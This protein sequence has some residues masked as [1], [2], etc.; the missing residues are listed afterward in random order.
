MIDKITIPKPLKLRDADV[1]SK[2][3]CA[4]AEHMGTDYLV[5]EAIQVA[6][7]RR[8]RSPRLSIL[9]DEHVVVL[10]CVANSTNDQN[11]S[12]LEKNGKIVFD[13]HAGQGISDVAATKRTI[14]VGY[15]DVGVMSDNKISNE[16]LAVFDH[17]GRFLTGYRSSTTERVDVMDCYCIC[18]AGGE[19]IAFHSYPSLQLV[20]WVAMRK[21]HS[22]SEMP[23]IACGSAMIAIH[24]SILYAYSPYRK[25]SSLFRIADDALKLNLDFPSR[26][27]ALRDGR[28]LLLD[29]HSAKILEPDRIA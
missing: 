13:F 15:H 4:I 19:E 5:T 20:K 2:S 12:I 17:S 6:L 21:R 3:W 18:N 1:L 10:D 11:G 25:K 28:I 14:V 9:D 24:N 22:F 27:V 8:Y 7:P 23:P 26:P 16:G 29:K